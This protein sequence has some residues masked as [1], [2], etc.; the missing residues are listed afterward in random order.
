MSF[1]YSVY[2][3]TANVVKYVKII[4]WLYLGAPKIESLSYKPLTTQE[5]STPG[6]TLTCTSTGGPASTVTWTKDCTPVPNDVNHLQSQTLLDGDTGTYQSVLT[7]TGPDYGEYKCIVTNSKASAASTGYTITAVG[8]SP[9]GS[10]SCKLQCMMKHTSYI[11][12]IIIHVRYN[13]FVHMWY[14]TVGLSFG[15]FLQVFKLQSYILHWMFDCGVIELD[16]AS[17]L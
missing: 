12:I 9:S 16:I 6:F 14:A 4:I 15:T 13:L 7:V 1:Q 17:Q 8:T 5:A 10:T 3:Q 2:S 11:Y